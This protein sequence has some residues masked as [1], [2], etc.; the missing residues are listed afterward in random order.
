[1][2]NVPGLLVKYKGP[3]SR[4]RQL[5]MIE[6]NYLELIFNKLVANAYHY[7]VK[8]EPDRPKKLLTMVWLKFK[9]T[10]YPSESIAFDGTNN[11]YASAPLKIGDMQREI[12]IVHPE[13][14]SVRKFI[15]SIQA[16]KDNQIPIKD[17]LTK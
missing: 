17:A 4:G 8:M 14:Q 11:A 5:G 12:E 1:M 16:A 2:P 3:G 9:E 10:N 15:V 7:D 6:T 13:T